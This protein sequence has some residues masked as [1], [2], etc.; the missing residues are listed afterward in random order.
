[1]VSARTF[2]L[3]AL[4]LAACSLDRS[5]LLGD[6]E[7][8]DAGRDSGPDAPEP[9][10]A[11]PDTPEVPDAGCVPGAVVELA[12]LGAS[13]IPLGDPALARVES[14]IELATQPHRH[15]AL[16]V[17]G[18]ARA[19]LDEGAPSTVVTDPP[20][21]VAYLPPPALPSFDGVPV[22]LG[23][24]GDEYTAT[25]VGE[26]F[27]E[28]GTHRFRVEAD[29]FAVLE[30]GDDFELS[31]ELDFPQR[32]DAI[33]ATEGWYE[34]RI[35]HHDRG[36]PAALHVEHAPPGGELAPIAR[37]RVRELPRLRGRELWGWPSADPQADPSGR[38]LDFD[39]SNRDF[40][41]G[42]PDELGLDDRD[43][44]SARWVGRVALPGDAMV[45]ARSDDGHR[46]WLD[47][48]FLGGA[49]DAGEATYR[50]PWPA[51][52]H[53]L[54]V[55][56]TD[57]G[58]DAELR[59]TADGAVLRP[60]AFEPRTRFGGDV[61]AAGRTLDLRV[62]DGTAESTELDVHVPGAASALELS[63]R[64]EAPMPEG[65]RVVF[66]GPD[67]VERP[68]VLTEGAWEREGV[69]TVR[70]VVPAGEVSGRWSFEVRNGGAGEARLLG[71]GA[72]A[73][74][75]GTTPHALEGTFTTGAIDLGGPAQLQA[76]A[77]DA[78]VFAETGVEVA[79]RVAETATRLPRAPFVTVPA[80]AIEPALQGE[81]AQ[82]RVTLRG[83]GHLSPRVEGIALSGALCR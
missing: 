53:D 73:H 47:G 31:A 45:F 39:P 2:L 79:V 61:Y 13:T 46:V 32:A 5:S 30:V 60:E 70:L 62:P 3:L 80:G 76:I 34:L 40:G 52:V 17:K 59:I 75:A 8:S 51:G 44:W 27:L 4:A 23:L 22:G 29:D 83:P 77:L 12:D 10:D 26:I 14:G 54:V 6:F 35:A 37:T 55:E 16:L 82:V 50:S 33:I 57:E 49:A 21:G 18:F 28:A 72:L 78:H 25:Y 7:P 24:S 9:T 41:A 63:A 56:L 65:V 15:G 1:M 69:H 74:V 67:A 36:G 68:V 58:G 66:T 11:G 38:R 64:L 20:T 42:R 43:V 71:I 48:V 19:L 81:F